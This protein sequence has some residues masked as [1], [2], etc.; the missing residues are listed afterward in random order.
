MAD[1]MRGGFLSGLI[2]PA[3]FTFP[4]PHL[5]PLGLTEPS[6]DKRSWGQVLDAEN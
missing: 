4:G 6:S 3:Q 5:M 2:L 1:A